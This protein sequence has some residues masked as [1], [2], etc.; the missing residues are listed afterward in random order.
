MQVINGFSINSSFIIIK[1]E[2]NSKC[3]NALAVFSSVK[4]LLDTAASERKKV[5]NVIE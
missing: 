4:I 2:F 5:K 3:F 1:V